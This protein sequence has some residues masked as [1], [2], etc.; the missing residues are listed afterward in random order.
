MAREPR[1]PFLQLQLGQCIDVPTQ[2]TPA[3]MTAAAYRASRQ[4]SDLLGT[5]VRFSVRRISPGMYRLTHVDPSAPAPIQSRPASPAAETLTPEERLEREDAQY[6]DRVRK[7][8]RQ[9][10]IRAEEEAALEDRLE[11]LRAAAERRR[12]V[13]KAKAYVEVR[14]EL[15]VINN[16]SAH[17]AEDRIEAKQREALAKERALASDTA[18]RDIGLLDG[19]DEALEIPAEL[20]EAAARRRALEAQAEAQIQAEIEKERSAL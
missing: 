9:R 17:E 19:D 7:Q 4:A 13:R 5:P 6:R 18:L 11:E 14:A 2:D 16:Q 3:Q 10:L 12:L 20:R 1:Y 8:L 15:N